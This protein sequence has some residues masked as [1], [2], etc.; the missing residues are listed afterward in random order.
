M[1]RIELCLQHNYL[2][3]KVFIMHSL[4]KVRWVC[5]FPGKGPVT[6]LRML[7][8]G[9]RVKSGATVSEAVP[10]GRMELD[11]PWS[12]EARRCDS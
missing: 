10:A 12:G 7:L 11:F 8:G 9:G 1:T 5:E 4:Q 3:R 6:L 2:E